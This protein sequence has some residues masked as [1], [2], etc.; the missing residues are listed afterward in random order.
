VDAAA[1]ARNW[2]RRA[3]LSCERS[4]ARRTNGVVAYDKTVWSWHPLLMSSWRRCVGPTGFRQTKFV[5]DGDK[6]EVVA[7][8]STA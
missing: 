7:E 4:P 2:N 3:G 5:S 1:L 8:E 6:K